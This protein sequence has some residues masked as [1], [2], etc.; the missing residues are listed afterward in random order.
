MLDG[1]VDPKEVAVATRRDKKR[2]AGHTPF[3]LCH[4][5]G[6]VRPGAR[7]DDADVLAAIAE[8]TGR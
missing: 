6:D 5:P 2:L 1:G 4:A 8:L 3:V 7:L